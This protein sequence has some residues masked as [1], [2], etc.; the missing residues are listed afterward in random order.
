MTQLSSVPLSNLLTTEGWLTGKHGGAGTI[1]GI[2]SK[3]SGLT[4]DI[5]LEI[6]WDAGNKSY[7]KFPD[8][9]INI[10]VDEEWQPLVNHEYVE[11]QIDLLQQNINYVTRSINTGRMVANAQALAS[12]HN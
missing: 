5:Y 9:C 10:T 3:P 6:E 4:F 11:Y 12:I 8:E 7:P 2:H 1:V